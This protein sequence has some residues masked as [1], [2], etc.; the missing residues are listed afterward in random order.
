MFKKRGQVWIETVLYTLIGLT[1]M[2]GLMWA[3]TPKINTLIDETAIEQAR[4]FLGDFDEA[5]ARTLYSSGMQ[6]EF[7]LPLKKGEFIVN[8]LDNSVSYVLRGTLKKFSEVNQLIPGD[9]SILTKNVS[10]KKYDVYL[11]VNYSSLGLNLTYNN[12]DSEKIFNSAPTP[13]PIL[14]SNKGGID[15]GIDISSL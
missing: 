5:L 9:I 6:I 11:I 10:T 7:N 3:I 13:Y 1:I 15:K 8:G 14:I 2:G 4:G 12:K